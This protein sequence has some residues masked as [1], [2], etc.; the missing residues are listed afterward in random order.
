MR[1]KRFLKS[2]NLHSYKLRFIA[3]FLLCAFAPAQH[4]ERISMN[5]LA[6]KKVD[7]RLVATQGEVFY[8]SDGKM[9]THIVSPME[10]IMVNNSKGDV[11]VYNPKSNEVSMQFNYQ[12]SSETSTLYY[13]LQSKDN[14]LGLKSAGFIRNSSKYENNL[15][16][17][18]WIPP[19]QVA[20]YF[21]FA[22]L[23]Y[24]KG[25]PVFLKFT[26][27]KDKPIKKVYFY[28]FRSVGAA[29]FPESVVQI[30]YHEKDSIVEK[31]SY[32]NI[33]LNQQAQSPYFDYSIPPNARIIK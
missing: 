6:K 13:F 29:Q 17:T 20:K 27:A 16:I 1:N 31:I 26:D 10:L 21:A 9:V 23:V 11:L 8:K 22:E 19:L 24:S 2:I 18:R 7:G 5:M 3:V 28:N 4:F 12:F 25:T 14:D 33:Q 15:L 32:S 30:S